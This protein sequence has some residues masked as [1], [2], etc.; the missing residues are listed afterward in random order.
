MSVNEQNRDAL[1]SSATRKMLDTHRQYKTPPNFRLDALGTK[2]IAL[3]LTINCYPIQTRPYSFLTTTRFVSYVKRIMKCPG[4][5]EE[6][7]TDARFCVACGTRIERLCP[8][9]N[10]ALT[11]GAK[12]C[13]LCGTRLEGVDEPVAARTQLLESRRRGSDAERRQLTV[14]FCDL[15]GS[16]AL[17]ERLDPEDL[18]ELLAAYQQTCGDVIG[19]YDGHIARYVG[20]GLL[21]YFGYPQAHEDDP[22]RAVNAGLGIIEAIEALNTDIG[23]SDITLAVRIGINTGMV[24][25][26]DI[27]TGERREEMGIVG[28]TPNIAAR[29]QGLAEPGT[30]VIGAPTQRLVDGLFICED[31]GLERVKGVSE[32]VAV[33]RVREQSDAP[34]R[35]EAAASRGLTPLVGREEE[36]GLVLK[37]W[38]RSRTVRGKPCSSPGKRELASRASFAAFRS[39]SL[40]SFA[41]ECSI[42][43]RRFT[44][45]ALSIR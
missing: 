1:C 12:Y 41:T 37:R 6:N 9:C 42:T 33:Y 18:R 20:D 44:V 31:L 30:V 38:D 5:A 13:H 7:P 14:M 8:S 10:A 26:G 24:V 4:C 15:V 17:S 2:A 21:V 34:S 28:D 23:C 43:A 39:A 11:L 27:G 32:P 16:T 25:A 19:R 45:T 3:R 36:L 40:T 35:F 29:L 22:Q